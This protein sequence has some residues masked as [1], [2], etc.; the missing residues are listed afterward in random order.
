MG[1]KQ[2]KEILTL[3]FV[4]SGSR[5]VGDHQLG[6]SEQGPRRRDSLLLPDA[7]IRDFLKNDRTDSQIDPP[8]PLPPFLMACRSDADLA[9]GISGKEASY[10]R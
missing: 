2:I 6:G 9:R 8:F 5:L 4:K 7:K 10:F 3:V 1:K